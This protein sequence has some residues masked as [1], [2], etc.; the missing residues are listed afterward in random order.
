MGLIRRP[1]TV[2]FSNRERS[3][4]TVWPTRTEWARAR[5]TASNGKLPDVPTAIS[6]YATA[7]EI[8][9]LRT[10]L[11]NRLAQLGE[12]KTHPYPFHRKCI[13]RALELIDR[14]E[15]PL[16][17][18]S[19]EGAHDILAPFYAR[20]CAARAEL[21]AQ[22]LSTQTAVDDEAWAAELQRRSR[23]GRV[24]HWNTKRSRTA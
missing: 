24:R 22:A 8:A 17:V 5:Q 7:D 21:Q 9:E 23:V 12:K 14:G 16:G 18:N 19:T 3:R 15:L 2:E 1:V 6:E 13:R 4:M 11:R 20:Y 10:A